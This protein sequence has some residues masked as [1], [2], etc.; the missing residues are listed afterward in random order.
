[1]TGAIFSLVRL[2]VLPPSLLG[3]LQRAQMGGVSIQSA[4]IA[5]LVKH[6]RMDPADAPQGVAELSDL[7]CQ[8]LHLPKNDASSLEKVLAVCCPGRRLNKALVDVRREDSEA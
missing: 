5:K 8:V 7:A 2:R 3:L 1:M 4:D 6:E